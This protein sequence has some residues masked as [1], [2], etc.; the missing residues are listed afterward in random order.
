MEQI[1]NMP[2]DRWMPKITSK[3]LK[4]YILAE[5]SFSCM[6]MFMK[7]LRKWGPISSRDGHLTL[8]RFRN[9]A[10]KLPE[11]CATAY[12]KTLCNAWNTSARY[13][14]GTNDCRIRGLAYGDNMKH[15][16]S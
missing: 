14:S 3:C 7:T 4:A 8:R 10:R 13:R 1:H 11:S 12:V 6:K 2:T 16:L 15:Y 5:D 9:A